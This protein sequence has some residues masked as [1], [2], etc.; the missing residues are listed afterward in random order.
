MGT[1]VLA[2]RST[3]RHV[4]QGAVGLLALVTAVAAAAA[5]TPAAL[6]RLVLTVAAWRGVS[7]LPGRRLRRPGLKLTV[8]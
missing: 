5:G 4:A 3:T 2:S 6:A 1:P 8:C 7:D